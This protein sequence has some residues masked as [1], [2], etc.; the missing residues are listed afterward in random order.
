[1]AK[2]IEAD[3]TGDSFERAFGKVVPPKRQTSE[4]KTAG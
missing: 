3:E 4:K 1:M 2:E